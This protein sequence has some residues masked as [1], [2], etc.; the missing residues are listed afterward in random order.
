M[1]GV[2]LLV[3]SGVC[4]V[5]GAA[6]ALVGTGVLVSGQRRRV[7]RSLSHVARVTSGSGYRAVDLN[8]S[9][10]DRV[11]GPI[12]RR[13]LVLGYRLTPPARADALRRRL[14]C[15]GNP[16]GWTVDTVVAGKAL[17]LLLGALLGLLLAA[18]AGAVLPALILVCAAAGLG[19]YVPN[20]ILHHKSYNRIEQVRRGL[21]DALDLMVVCVEAGLGFPAAMRQVAANTSGPVAGEFGRVL[22]E[23]QIGADLSSALR[24]L[25][26]RTPVE[27]LQR[28]CAAMVQA[29]SLGVGVSATLRVQAEEMRTKRSQRTEEAAQ[30]VPV[31][32]L[33][34]LIFCILPALFVVVLGPAVISIAATLIQQ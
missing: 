4:L 29:Q 9:V 6:L 5:F 28:F 3:I 12:G 32:I 34:P 17:G 8:S 15:A 11:T 2:V 20:L 7:N 23:M 18:V 16:A 26:D 10:R 21:P 33:F 19:F 13:L 30:K 1:S 22:H 31:K 27:D 25:A 14:D 24:A